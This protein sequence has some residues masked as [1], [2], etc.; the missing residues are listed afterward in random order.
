MMSVL[1]D[2]QRA[3]GSDAAI[4]CSLPPELAQRPSSPLVS[5]PV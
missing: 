1:D 5:R 4:V 2:A 3:T